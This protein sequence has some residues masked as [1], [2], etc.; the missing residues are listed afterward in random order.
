MTIF[1]DFF[2]AQMAYLA[3]RIDWTGLSVIEYGAQHARHSLA[4]LGLG[5][6]SALAIEGRQSN[7]DQVQNVDGF[8]L[9]TLCADVRNLKS[10]LGIFDVGLILGVLYHLDAPVAF[11]RRELPR[12]QKHL[13]VWTHYVTKSDANLEQDGYAGGIWLDSGS[14]KSSSLAP[15]AAFWFEKSELIR[16]LQ[17]NGFHVREVIEM[18]TPVSPQ[19]PGV[20]IYAVRRP[21]AT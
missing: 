16:C 8:P 2:E 12:I 13:F 14:G 11:L 4:C 18:P 6:A 15:L 3:R 7:L 20:M 9:E 5:A 21:H 19:Y 1:D 10:T 17:D